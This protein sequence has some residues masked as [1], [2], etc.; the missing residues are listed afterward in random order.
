MHCPAGLFWLVGLCSFCFGLFSISHHRFRF[1][2][3][4]Q[5]W[6][7]QRF[8]M[9]LF[10]S[11]IFCCMPTALAFPC[12]VIGLFALPLCGAALTFFAAAKKVSKESGLTPPACRCPP[13]A[14]SGVVRARD[15]PS[16]PP[17]SVTKHSSASSVALRAPPSGITVSPVCLASCSC[18]FPLCRLPT[19]GH[20]DDCSV[21]QKSSTIM[22]VYE[23]CHIDI[24]YDK[25]RI[26][27]GCF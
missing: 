10:R 18:G 1:S 11:R 13:L 16:R 22:T 24:S 19:I 20:S 27:R 4:L 8:L 9:V 12:I 2:V 14:P 7:C 3:A 15:L 25:R 23:S 26:I 5:F 21:D 17:P 6:P